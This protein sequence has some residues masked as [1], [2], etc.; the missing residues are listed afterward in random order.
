M[1][2]LVTITAA[3]GAVVAVAAAVA[4]AAGASV[5]A[6]VAVAAGAV[7]AAGACVAA[8]AVVGAAVGVAAPQATKAAVALVVPINASIC[9]RDSVVF[10]LELIL[11]FSSKFITWLIHFMILQLKLYS[12][13]ASVRTNRLAILRRKHTALHLLWDKS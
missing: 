5:G 11:L 10:L 2:P 13:V 8:G 9:R 6:V 1:P 12:N 7:V 4:V 3:V